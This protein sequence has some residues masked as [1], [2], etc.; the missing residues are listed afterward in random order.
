MRPA[1]RSV[2]RQARL[3]HRSRL[4]VQQPSRVGAA[5]SESSAE[6]ALRAQLAVRLLYSEVSVVRALQEVASLSVL[7]LAVRQAVHPAGP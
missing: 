5:Q 1:R 3:R 6:R 7:A 2:R 4:Q